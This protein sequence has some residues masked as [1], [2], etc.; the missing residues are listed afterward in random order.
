MIQSA[1]KFQEQR[2]N[3]FYFFKNVDPGFQIFQ[4]PGPKKLVLGPVDVFG[5]FWTSKNHDFLSHIDNFP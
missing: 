5:R 4:I 1:E 2:F 3:S